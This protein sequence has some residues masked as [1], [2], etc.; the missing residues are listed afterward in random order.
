MAPVWRS[1]SHPLEE[2]GSA[3][4]MRAFHPS[5]AVLSRQRLPV[6]KVAVPDPA[7]CQ[8]VKRARIRCCCRKGLRLLRAVLVEPA[9]G[10]RHLVAHTQHR[11]GVVLC[12]AC[13]TSAKGQHWAVHS[14]CACWRCIMQAQ[15]WLVQLH[16]P[17]L[18][19]SCG[20]ALHVGYP[21]LRSNSR[22]KAAELG[23]ARASSNTDVYVEVGRPATVI[24]T[25]P[26]CCSGVGPSLVAARVLAVAG[27]AGSSGQLFCGSTGATAAQMA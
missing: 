25:Q 21:M 9:L 24:E 19:L 7:W 27:G 4:G 10:Q 13:G 16:P 17:Y 15:Q 11:L 8:R 12:Y 14:S 22:W 6:A 18:R 2:V 1:A 26:A 3:D 23:T 20:L 5:P